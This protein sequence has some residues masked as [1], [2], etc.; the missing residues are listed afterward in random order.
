MR[1]DT[2]NIVLTV[3]FLIGVRKSAYQAVY[4]NENSE[5]ISSLENSKEALTIRYLCKLRTTLMQRFK[6]TDDA[7]VYDFKNLDGIEWYDAENISRLEKWGYSIILANKRAADYAVHFNTLIH[8]NIDICKDLFPDW[9][10][11]DYIKDLFIIPKY[12]SSQHLKYEFEKYMQNINFYPFQMFIHWKPKDIGNLLSSDGKFLDY[13][14]HTNNDCF[15]DRSKYRN[16]VDDVKNNIYSFIDNSYKTVLAVDCE[17]SDVYK[18]YGMLKNLNRTEIDKIEK[19][20]LYDDK[21]TTNGWDYIEKFIKIPVEH[22]EVQ[23][24]VDHKSIVDMRMATGICREFYVNDVSSFILLSSDSDYWGLISSLPE[25][26]FLVVIEY[27]KCGQAIKET[28]DSNGIY[29][30]SLDDFCTGNIDE[31]KRAVLLNE[32]TGLLPDLLRYNGK[33]LAYK[34]FELARIEADENE[35]MNFYNRYIKTIGLTVDDNGNF[36]FKIKN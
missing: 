2:K 3:A 25:A 10:V 6:K 8:D 24:V 13:L 31:L 18:L 35:V 29:Y 15:T 12:Q 23:R 26:D 7:I 4:G 19:I 9:I 22:I 17:N 34:L 27:A 28:L 36:G 5:L 32:L 21:H 14:Y 33:Q 1:T 11:W 30:C 16:A 20:I